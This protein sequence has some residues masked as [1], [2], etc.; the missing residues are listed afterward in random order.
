MSATEG[1]DDNPL[2]STAISLQRAEPKEGQGNVYVL[3]PLFSRFLVI[4]KH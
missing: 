2:D 1:G 4:P 3:S